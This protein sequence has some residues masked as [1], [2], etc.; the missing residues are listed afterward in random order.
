MIIIVDFFI[1]LCFYLFT[2]PSE[3]AASTAATEATATKT[4]TA[5][6]ASTEATTADNHAT[7]RTTTIGIT[8]TAAAGKCVAAILAAESNLFYGIAI[9]PFHY[10]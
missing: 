3:T 8:R 6:R 7:A 2:L 9:H 1:F 4:A 10:A 5:A